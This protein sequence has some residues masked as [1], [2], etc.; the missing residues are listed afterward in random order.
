MSDSPL[1]EDGWADV[2]VGIKYNLLRDVEMQRLVSAGATFELPVGSTRSLQGNGDGEFHAFITGGTQLGADYHLISAAGIRMPTDTS[3]ENQLLYWSNHIDRRLFW[4]DVYV[5]AEANWYHYLESGTA[6][7]VPLEGGDLFNLGAVDVAGNN[8]VTG[9]FGFKYA[10]Q[11]LM[12]L[13][14]AWELPL[15]EREGLLDN[16]LTVDCILRY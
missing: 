9:A 6:L 8:L 7:P 3:A 4:D 14:V 1:I 2:S 13:G 16:R 15:T 11:H 10:P 12:E 5:L